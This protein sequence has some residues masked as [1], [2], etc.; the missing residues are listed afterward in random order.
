MAN[1]YAA[2]ILLGLG[3][4][5]TS[6]LPALLPEGPRPNL[7]AAAA[8][9][10]ALLVGSTRGTV[11]G[12]LGGLILDLMGPGPLGLS[13]LLLAAASAGVGLGRSFIDRA[14]VL[15]SVLLLVVVAVGYNLALMLAWSLLDAPLLGREGVLA[16]LVPTSAWNAIALAAALVVGVR[17][18]PLGE[19][20]TAA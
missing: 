17:L 16:L 5:Q 15:F 11:W 9:V 1:L 12:F 10:G 4:I 7:L 20:D 19:P 8:L 18:V 13:A 3:L 14:N 6:F 2:G